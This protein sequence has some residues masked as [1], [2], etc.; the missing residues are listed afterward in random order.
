MDIVKNGIDLFSKHGSTIANAVDVAS[1]IANIVKTSKEIDREDK[2]LYELK[3]INLAKEANL[4]N[5][6]LSTPSKITRAHMNIM[7]T[8]REHEGDGCRGNGIKII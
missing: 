8:M 7:K 4:L 1:G 2:K 5:N 6:K 3:K